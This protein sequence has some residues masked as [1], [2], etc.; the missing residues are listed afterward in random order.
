MI[1]FIKN[2]KNFWSKDLENFVFPVMSPLD[3]SARDYWNHPNFQNSKPLLQAF[4]DH[5]P[6]YWNQFL[7]ELDAKEG[8]VSWT[9][10]VPGQ[11]LP[12]HTDKFYKLRTKYNVDIEKCSRYLIFLNDWV[13][14]HYVDFE[15]Q[16]ITRWKEGDVWRFDYRSHHCAANASKVDFITCQVNTCEF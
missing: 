1:K 8:T 10:I 4:D 7:V 2:I 14:G 3:I 11:V 5:L 12:V 13:L 6:N 16:S 15:E 9:N